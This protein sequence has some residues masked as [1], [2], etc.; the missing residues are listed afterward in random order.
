MNDKF[1]SDFENLN[2][3]VDEEEATRRLDQDDPFETLLKYFK[4]HVPSDR[5]SRLY[6]IFVNRDRDGKR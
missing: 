5:E 2:L 1:V 3:N 4:E 6:R